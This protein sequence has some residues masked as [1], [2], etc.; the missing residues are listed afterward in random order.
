MMYGREAILPSE[1]WMKSFREISSTEDY[2]KKLVTALTQVWEKAALNKPKETKKMTDGQEKYRRHLQFVEYKVG[3]YAMVSMT[4]KQSLKSWVDKTKRKLSAKLQ[5]RYSGPYLI[6]GKRSPVVYY[7]QIDGREKVTHAVNMKP[8][9]GK[10]MYT[11]PFVQRGF[12]KDEAAQTEAPKP[13]LLSDDPALNEAT[14]V[15]YQPKYTAAQAEQTRRD[16]RKQLRTERSIEM[17]KLFDES[18]SNEC[19]WLLDDYEELKEDESSAKYQSWLREKA[20]RRI[21][22][23]NSL[24]KDFAKKPKSEQEE[25]L[26]KLDNAG[27]TMEDMVEMELARQESN[28]E[29]SLEDSFEIKSQT[30]EPPQIVPKTRANKPRK[31]SSRNTIVT[32]AKARRS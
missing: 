28:W 11:T 16:N 5:P 2:V 15:G 6:T 4:P 14:R 32:R 20:R 19:S 22:I 10:L 21:I 31:L 27:Y 29:Q 13:L 1:T 7:L 24:Q 30:E 9:N 23:L 26:E 25:E 18:Q 3:D 8:F 17:N 12:N